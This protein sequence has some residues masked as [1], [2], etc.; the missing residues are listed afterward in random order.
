VIDFSGQRGGFDAIDQRFGN[1]ELHGENSAVAEG[2]SRRSQRDAKLAGGPTPA[3]AF[4]PVEAREK[5]MGYFR[6]G[7]LKIGGLTRRP[8]VRFDVDAIFAVAGAEDE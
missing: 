3:G 1:A 5:L 2:K 7:H 6:V 8:F 4:R